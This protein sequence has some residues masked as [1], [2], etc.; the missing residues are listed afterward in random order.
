MTA[1]KAKAT[2]EQ[3]AE[4]RVEAFF[5]ENAASDDCVTAQQIADFVERDAKTV[6]A[7]MRQMK[8]RDQAQFKN[9]Q[10]RINK[11][12]AT[13]LTTHYDKAKRVVNK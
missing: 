11:E 6:R 10:Y 2:K 1:A 4:Q 3:T 5:K 7:L 12:L 9:A 13:I 8:V